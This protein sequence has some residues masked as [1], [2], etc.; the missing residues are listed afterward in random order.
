MANLAILGGNK[1]VTKPVVGE[2]GIV[3]FIPNVNEKAMATIQ[4]LLKNGQLSVS[5][6]VPEFEAKF[7]EYIGAK[8]ALCQ[9]SGTMSIQ[10]GLFAMGIGRG[11]E[12]IVPS[13]TFFAS[14]T[15]ILTLGG[16]PVFAD[17]DKDTHCI[18]AEE[19]EK[20]IT[21]KTKAIVIVHVWGNPCDMDAIMA[22]AKKHN[23]KVLEDCSH[24]HGAEWNGKKIGSFGDVGVFS[25]QGEKL[26]ASGEGGILVTS[27]E[28]I[29][30]RAAA[31]GSY[32]RLGG[33]TFLS[34]DELAS[35]NGLPNIHSTYRGTALGMK[36]RP[37]PVSIAIAA[38]EL[39]RLDER[40]A[41]R[42]AN[43]K[44]LDKC[45]SDIDCIIPLKTLD[46]AER[47]YS[48]HYMRYDA[49]LNNG[50][51]RQTFLKAMAAEGVAIG[52][53]GYGALHYAPAFT[54]LDGNW[55]QCYPNAPEKDAPSLPVTEML[56]Q[57][58]FMA[59]PR[60]EDPNSKEVIEQYAEAY[61]KVI[62]STDEMLQYQK[63]NYEELAAAQAQTGRSR[64]ML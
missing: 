3:G 46:P 58:A 31:L 49:D 29:I 34:S 52:S 55:P 26:M 20:K 37:Y 27:D 21:P 15:P 18:T 13:F 38:S 44:Y 35:R 63:E 56:R 64:N 17:V 32:E 50:I 9:C 24:A 54:Q 62:S 41:I 22:V 1:T 12:V 47:V 43:A 57:S 45:L 60:F 10:A 23:L 5:P 11:D 40:N 42:N 28:E 14:A 6:I 7:K 53:C 4:E 2:N 61:H 19:I 59:G 48:Y 36:L 8:F 16:V 30:F 25:F 39:E 51:M 33:Q